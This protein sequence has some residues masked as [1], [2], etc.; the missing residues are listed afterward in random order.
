MQKNKMPESD[1]RCLDFLGQLRQQHGLH[2]SVSVNE[3]RNILWYHQMRM[4]LGIRFN[5][6]CNFQLTH[7]PC[8]ENDKV[9]HHQYNGLCVHCA[10]RY[11]HDLLDGLLLLGFLQWGQC[12]LQAYLITSTIIVDWREFYTEQL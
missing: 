7:D 2:W 12:S 8:K 5:V 1:N 6:D 10:V 3:L 11:R 9:D 4:L